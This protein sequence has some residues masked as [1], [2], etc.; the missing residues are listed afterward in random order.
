[1]VYF[2]LFL[3]LGCAFF[4]LFFWL[5][6][7]SRL[8]YYQG[9]P[10]QEEEKTP[11]VSIVICAFNEATNLKEYLPKILGQDYPNFEVLVVDDAS[12]DGTADVLSTLGKD[13]PQLSILRLSYPEGKKTVGK[14]N[15]LSQ[16]I[17]QAK[18]TLLLV[19]DADCYPKGDQ[20]VKK[21]VSAIEGTTTIGLAY[22]PYAKQTG[23]LN[24]FIRFE[25]VYTAI[26]YMSFSLWKMPYMGV[27][28]NMIYQKDLFIKAGGFEKHK[29]VASGDDD[30]FISEVA[31][32]M[33]TTVVIHES[34]Y[35]YSNPKKSW[36]AYFRQKSR[37][38][39]TG[40][41]YKLIH[42]IALGLLSLSHFGFYFFALMAIIWEIKLI[43]VLTIVFG[44]IFFKTIIFAKIAHKLDEG[45]LIPIIP[46][47]DVV[48][49]LYYIILTP[50]LFWGKTS[51]WK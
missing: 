15:A 40:T 32:E 19:T 1:M 20:W 30:L 45:D 51:K 10:E 9:N 28:R 46:F 33:N 18:H 42:Q 47:L 44:V 8:A 36:K 5:S 37:H 31:N 35:M 26:Q 11:P 34:S 16:G 17:R 22:G 6:I 29:H 41:H 27:G 13:H 4:Q 21:M 48:Y 38:V 12:T 50:A 39:T 7:F 23:L 14:K 25:T 3:F 43:F 2:I 24:A 49:I